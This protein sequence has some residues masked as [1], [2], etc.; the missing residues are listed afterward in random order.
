MEGS[1]KV[2]LS[3][4]I[5]AY[6]EE[7]NIERALASV[8]WADEI[9][10]V[11]SGSTDR[12]VEICRRH[13]ARVIERPWEGFIAQKNFALA[14]AENEWVLSIDADE[15]VSPRLAESIKSVLAGDGRFDGYMVKR[16]V[17]YLGRWINHC[18]WYPDWRVRL[19]RKS[20]ARWVGDQVHETLEVDGAV[21]RI[22]DGDLNHYS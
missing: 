13:G 5:I 20:K 7:A 14:Q 6:N 3:V 11:D 2:G 1:K 16:R 18:G 21:G 9:V 22:A 17:F 4:V 15:E 19:V 12:T 10:V 8:A